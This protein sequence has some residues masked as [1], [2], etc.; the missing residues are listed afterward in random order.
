M[1]KVR[2]LIPYRKPGGLATWPPLPEYVW[3]SIDAAARAH[4]FEFT[5]GSSQLLDRDSPILLAKALEPNRARALAEELRGSQV[6]TVV[7]SD[8][9]AGMAWRWCRYRA[10]L[11]GRTLMRACYS[12]A[13]LSV[14][15][16]LVS[17]SPNWRGGLVLGLLLFCMLESVSVALWRDKAVLVDLSISDDESV[18]KET[19]EGSSLSPERTT[20][21]AHDL[22]STV[23]R[24]R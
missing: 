6:H 21:D 12:M 15:L 3:D 11:L 24:Q 18:E 7:E 14:A 20:A 1:R 23:Q 2:L 9:P 4:G 22:R 5:P 16:A 10:D 19:S 17:T 8:F 13:S